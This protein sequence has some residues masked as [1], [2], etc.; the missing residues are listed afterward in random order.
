MSKKRATLRRRAQTHVEQA[1]RDARRPAKRT[2]LRR[3]ARTERPTREA[4]LSQAILEALEREGAPLTP[5]ELGARLGIAKRDG[6]ALEVA[7]QSL[8]TSGALLRNRAGS[9]LVA[10]R[11]ALVAGRIEGHPDG[12]GFLVPDAPGAPSITLSA[13]S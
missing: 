2:A 4:N 9:V 11:I 1:P 6:A 12:F 10:R 5:E 7:L 8:L 3:R 13:T